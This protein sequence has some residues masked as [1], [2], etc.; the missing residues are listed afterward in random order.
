MMVCDDK[1]VRSFKDTTAKFLTCKSNLQSWMTKG[2]SRRWKE[3]QTGLIIL[4]L[5]Y[6]GAWIMLYIHSDNAN[7]ITEDDATTFVFT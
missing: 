5:R 4:L 3:L 2:E 1:N 7:N 6:N